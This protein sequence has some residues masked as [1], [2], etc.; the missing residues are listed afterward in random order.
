[1]VARADTSAPPDTASLKGKGIPIVS[2]TAPN[3]LGS[4][5]LNIIR[6]N[7]YPQSGTFDLAYDTYNGATHTEDWFGYV[8]TSPHYFYKV[9]HWYGH[10]DADPAGG[11]F[12]MPRV[13]VHHDSIWSDVPGAVLAPANYDPA[14]ATDFTSFTISFPAYAGDGIRVIGAPRGGQWIGCAELDVFDTTL[15]TGISRPL[16]QV[17]GLGIITVTP[18]PMH[19]VAT[20]NV[21]T[22]A[23][24]RSLRIY[25]TDGALVH[26]ATGTMPASHLAWNGTDRTGRTVAPGLY[27]YSLS[28]GRGEFSGRIIKTE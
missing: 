7:N 8:F 15:H 24:I 13:Q 20:F 2:V 18:H 25:H 14:T 11:V 9:T 17:S 19:T 5:D 1:V 10:R 16:G 23:V 6:D 27:F 22:D 21:G 28:T 3:G 4:R 12:V 26:E